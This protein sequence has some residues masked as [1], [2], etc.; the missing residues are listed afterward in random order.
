M[1][2]FDCNTANQTEFSE[3]RL[4]KIVGG[5]DGEKRNIRVPL[6]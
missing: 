4:L 5:K 3:N 6:F 1:K 2:I